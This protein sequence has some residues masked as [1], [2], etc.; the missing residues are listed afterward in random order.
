MYHDLV[1]IAI[2]REAWQKNVTPRVTP[3]LP[4]LSWKDE[5]D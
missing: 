4:W 1:T 2:Y 3:C 5:G